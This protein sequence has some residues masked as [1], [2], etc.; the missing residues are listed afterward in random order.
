LN[1]VFFDIKESWYNIS[2]DILTKQIEKYELDNEV[3]Q[4]T[5]ENIELI[6]V[7]LLDQVNHFI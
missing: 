1:K 2:R 7:S 6:A 3:R 5:K 4:L